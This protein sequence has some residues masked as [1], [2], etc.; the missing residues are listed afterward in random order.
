MQNFL[1]DFSQ[2]IKDLYILIEK[3]LTASNLAQL[4]YLFQRHH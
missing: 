4:D 3:N 2:H 1:V